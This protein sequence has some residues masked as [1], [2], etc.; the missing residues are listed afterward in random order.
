M[1]WP[2]AKLPDDLTEILQKS[3]AA[4]KGK[5]AA[6]EIPKASESSAASVPSEPANGRTDAGAKVPQQGE[7]VVSTAPGARTE[8]S[9]PGTDHVVPAQYEVRELS[10]VHPFEEVRPWL[11]QPEEESAEAP[12]Q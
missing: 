2:L 8:V 1:L 3:L 11:S 4:A 9:V 7:P 12:K 5:N 6:A 10:D